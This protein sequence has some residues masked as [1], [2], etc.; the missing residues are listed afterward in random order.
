MGAL[1]ASV[2][3]SL[4]QATASTIAHKYRRA[5]K[6]GTGAKLTFAE[7]QLLAHLGALDLVTR[8]ENEELTNWQEV[9]AR[10]SSGTTG[11]T[12]AATVRPPASG[13][14]PQSPA[15]DDRSYIKALGLAT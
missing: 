5:L 4:D 15:T 3:L 7:L 6:N 2:S 10:I 14:S 11:S 1:Q 8:A 9:L 12:T 13:R